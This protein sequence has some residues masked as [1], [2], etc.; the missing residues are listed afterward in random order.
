M[1][2]GDV[3]GA[4]RAD[5]QNSGYGRSA[6]SLPTG[7]D[8]SVVSGG[9]ATTVPDVLQL[10]FLCSRAFA[11]GDDSEEA[12]FEA[13]ESWERVREWLRSHSATEVKEAAEARGENN[14]VR[15]VEKKTSV[16]SLLIRNI[17]PPP[18]HQ[19]C[20]IRTHQPFLTS[21]K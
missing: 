15:L 3:Y 4:V 6:R 17:H 10:N 9:D 11:P 5:S 20:R 7:D 21:Q 12:K 2:S 1:S 13:D 18:R 14:M 16:G 19:G 8:R